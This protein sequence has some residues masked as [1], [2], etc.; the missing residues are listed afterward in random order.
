MTP[1]QLV[2]LVVLAAIWGASFLFIRMAVSSFGPFAL[3]ELRVLIGGLL[4]WLL[5]VVLRRRALWIAQ[6]KKYVVLGALNAAIPFSLIAA[7]ELVI[8]ASLAA[9]LNALTPVFTAIVSAMWLG[10]R[11][12]LKLA[13]GLLVAFAGVIVSVGWSP[14][15]LTLWPLLAAGAIAVASLF[16]AIGSNY[17]SRTF[18]A[19]DPLTMSIG[20]NIGAALVL[21]PFALGTIPREMP[22]MPATGA[23]LAL[24]IVCTAGAYQIYFWLLNNVGPTRT[25][26]VTFLVPVFGLLWG[27]LILKEP[28]TTGMIGGLVLVFVGI[29]LMADLRMRPR[30]VDTDGSASQARSSS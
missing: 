5:A 3:M 2:G 24:A 23:M 22:S 13:L 25:T 28:L 15:E 27:N 17:S 20:Q 4:L 26:S 21:L 30:A 6:W 12:G 29:V 16:Y 11:I 7:A 18:P 10:Q 9:I 8:P 1:L 14:L 19:A